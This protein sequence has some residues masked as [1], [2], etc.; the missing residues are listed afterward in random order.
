MREGHA[1]TFVADTMLGRNAHVFERDDRMLVRERVHVRRRAQHAD[2]V[3]RQ[4]D[5][6]H[7]MRT[8]TLPTGE[9]RLE[10]DVLRL[11]ERSDVPL[12]A[13]EDIA[14][15]VPRRRRGQCVDVRP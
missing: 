4:R 3:P 10:E 13:V 7:R 9:P 2:P 8:R 14:I 11:V 12:D 5:D 6:E 15:A 1:V